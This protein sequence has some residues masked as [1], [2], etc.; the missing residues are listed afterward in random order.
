MFLICPQQV[1]NMP[2][3]AKKGKYCNTGFENEFASICI[4]NKL[5]FLKSQLFFQK[6]LCKILRMK[7]RKY[8]MEIHRF[9]I[10]KFKYPLSQ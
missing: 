4:N 9:F 5:L 10:K 8:L 3:E 7:K 2:I 1:T 6:Y